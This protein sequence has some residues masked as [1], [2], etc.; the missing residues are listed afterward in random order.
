MDLKFLSARFQKGKV[1]I[2]NWMM[3]HHNYIH[4]PQGK[5]SDLHSWI[6]QHRR[7]HGPSDSWLVEFVVLFW[8]Q[9]LQSSVG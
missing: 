3:E 8:P 2:E 4:F 6:I 9:W 5:F 7:Q 1:F